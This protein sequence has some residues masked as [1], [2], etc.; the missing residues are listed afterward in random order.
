[1]NCERM[2][3]QHEGHQ[4]LLALGAGTA[5]ERQHLILSDTHTH[6]EVC[7][8]ADMRVVQYACILHTVFV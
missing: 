1:M 6:R 8:H 2:F 4:N 7:V 5:G 3:T